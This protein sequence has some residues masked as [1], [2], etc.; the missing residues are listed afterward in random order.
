MVPS[1][2]FRVSPEL[3]HDTGARDALLARIRNGEPQDGA[4]LAHRRG[5]RVYRLRIGGHELVAKHYYARSR[6]KAA[7]HALRRTK[8][9]RSW[10]AAWKLAELG[11]PACS[12]IMLYERRWLG[13]RIAATFVS[14]FIEGPSLA[15][16]LEDEAVPLASRRAVVTRLVGDLRRLH[17]VG[18]M[19][20]D[21]KR[22]NFV[23]DG[24][25]AVMV[26]LDD[27]RP[28]PPGPF[29]RY[30]RLR[31]WRVLL[32]TCR[33]NADWREFYLSLMRDHLPAVEL[34]YVLRRPFRSATT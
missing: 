32:H 2:R 17:D 11:I 3:D 19:Q 12:P 24:L 7:L 29:G 13:A 10:R 23:Y 16:F 15:K 14:G 31:D 34:D 21:L 25:C 6:P 20:G 30:Q 4:T 9:E 33:E 1:E 22:S 26:D 27:V 5:S 28:L 8:A 18:W